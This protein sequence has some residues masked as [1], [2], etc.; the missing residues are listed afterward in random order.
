LE[1]SEVGALCAES[2]GLEAKGV[3]DCDWTDEV[4]VDRFRKNPKD[5]KRRTAKMG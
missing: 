4:L 1:E 3:F 5:G 2:A